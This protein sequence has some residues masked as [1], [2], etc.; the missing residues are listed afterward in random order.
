MNDLIGGLLDFMT[1]FPF[2]QI[3]DKQQVFFLTN[4]YY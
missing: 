2:H 4:N 1:L 3:D